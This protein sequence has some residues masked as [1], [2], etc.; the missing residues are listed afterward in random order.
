MLGYGLVV[1]F[2]LGFGFEESTEMS[3]LK[4]LCWEFIKLFAVLKTGKCLNEYWDFI[5]KN[6]YLTFLE[7]CRNITFSDSN[8]PFCVNETK[9]EHVSIVFFIHD[10]ANFMKTFSEH[11]TIRELLVKSEVLFFLYHMYFIENYFNAFILKVW[12]FNNWKWRYKRNSRYRLVRPIIVY[13]CICFWKPLKYL[14]P[15]NVVFPSYLNG[16]V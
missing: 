2:W 15:S 6:I 5:F 13:K 9:D 10:K 1:K 11:G 8:L 3:N 14:R 16:I 4:S 7:A 12:N